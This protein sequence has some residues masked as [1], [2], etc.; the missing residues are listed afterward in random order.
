MKSRCIKVSHRNLVDFNEVLIRKRIVRFSYNPIIM[1]PF[2]AV[3]EII[4]HIFRPSLFLPFICVHNNTR[5]QK[6]SKKRG[7]P[8]SIHHMS[9]RERT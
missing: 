3:E 2:V 4:S 5:E 7:R 9:G 1:L 6:T 8:G